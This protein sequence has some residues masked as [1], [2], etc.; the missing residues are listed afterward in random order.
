MNVNE[1]CKV[2]LTRSLALRREEESTSATKKKLKPIS[3]PSSESS[4]SSAKILPNYSLHASY[5]LQT[6]PIRNRHMEPEQRVKRPEESASENN[7]NNNR[8]IMQLAPHNKQGIH[9]RM[10]CTA[11]SH[12]CPEPPA[13]RKRFVS[14]RSAGW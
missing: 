11:R 4:E 14:H 12:C 10:E 2:D 6:D 1:A 7:K 9:K 8:L 13:C 5:T 3:V